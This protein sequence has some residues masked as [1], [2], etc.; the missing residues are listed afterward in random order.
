MSA[1]DVRGAGAI[2]ALCLRCLVVLVAVNPLALLVLLAVSG[3]TETAT[4]ILAYL[5]YVLLVAAFPVA[6]VGFPAGLLTAH[7]LA[8]VPKERVH[9][10]VF[11]LV[12]GILSP[13]LC[14]WWGLLGMPAWAWIVAAA[15]GVVGAGGARWWTGRVRA[16]RQRWS[17]EQGA[18]LPWGRIG[19]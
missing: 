5:P 19:P 3:D 15:E 12:G 13:A 1:S 7:L 6:L 9:V 4:H 14:A 2:A 18:A 11:A 17:E 8:G 10:L 16:G